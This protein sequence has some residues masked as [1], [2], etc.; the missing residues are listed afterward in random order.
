MRER[1]IL[2]ASAHES[3][4]N[5]RVRT[6]LRASA[7]EMGEN[8]RTRGGSGMREGNGGAQPMSHLWPGRREMSFVVRAQQR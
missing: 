2:R 6:F 4:E 3:G 1:A 5:V 7:H 8:V